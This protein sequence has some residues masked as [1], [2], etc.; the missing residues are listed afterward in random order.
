MKWLMEYR[1]DGVRT[2]VEH[3]GRLMGSAV[4]NAMEAFYTGLAP[5][6]CMSELNTTLDGFVEH[7]SATMSEK[8]ASE[9]ALTQAVVSKYFSEMSPTRFGGIRAVQLDLKQPTIPFHCKLD[10]VTERGNAVGTRIVD[11]KCLSGFT[12]IE[13][14][15]MKYELGSQPGLYGAALLFMDYPEPYEFVVDYLIKGK[16][17]SGRYKAT[18]PVLDTYAFEV[19]P[20]KIDMA[21][22]SAKEANNGMVALWAAIQEAGGMEHVRMEDIPRR[23]IN[24]IKPFASKKYPCDFYVACSHNAHPMTF[25][26][27]FTT[28][29]RF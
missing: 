4:S 25:E 8:W 24:C 14:E 16:A 15:N 29:R 27:Q 19:E 28:E 21:M 12:D 3:I 23:V 2:I 9:V 11:Q 1:G 13:L 5:A 22:A 10:L 17:A 20:W 18:E 26:G 7:G 6:H